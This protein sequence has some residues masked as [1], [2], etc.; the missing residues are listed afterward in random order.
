MSL[1]PPDTIL[2][3]Q[4]GVTGWPTPPAL[5]NGH[6]TAYF[7]AAPFTPAV[8]A[9][10]Q[11]AA[12]TVAARPS[13]PVWKRITVTASPSGRTCLISGPSGSCTIDGLEGGTEYTFTAVAAIDDPALVSAPSPTSARVVVRSPPPAP[14]ASTASAAVTTASVKFGP[15]VS[16][17][18]NSI[19]S[20]IS[21]PGPG[22]VVQVGT[23]VGPSRVA[24]TACRMRRTIPRAGTYR[25]S[26][27][28]TA[29]AAALRRTRGLRVRLIMTFTPTGGI[30]QT[31][32][33]VVRLA[34]AA[35]VPPAHSPLSGPAEPVA[36]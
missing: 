10:V 30:A 31:T 5:A 29:S 7:L 32:T 6:A 15:R 11:S 14:P 17:R 2:R 22:T 34:R 4:P 19:S 23:L 18:G 24:R 21:F 26:C 25:I 16:V 33:Q 1:I 20:W 3:F 9:A 36:G 28:L 13:G 12:I 27:P 8:I 35:K